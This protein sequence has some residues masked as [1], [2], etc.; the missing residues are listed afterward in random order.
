MSEPLKLSARI[1]TPM[2]E[3]HHAL[4]DAEALRVWLAEH[5]EV[6][7]P[8]RYAFWGRHTPGGEDPHQRP[9]HVDDH[10]V[11]FS[12]RLGGEDTTVEFSLEEEGAESTIVTL[13]Q[14]HFSHE[15]MMSGD[16]DLG[17]LHTFWAMAIANLADHLEGRELLPRCDFTSSRME[18]RFVI[19]ASPEAVYDSLIDSEK[20]TRWFGFPVGIEPHVGGRFAMG[21]LD[22]GDAARIID[23]DPGRKLVTDWGPTGVTTWELEGTGGKTRLTFVQS[24][25]DTSRP[26]YGAW[27]G[28][29]SGLAELR[30]FHEVPGWQPM[31]V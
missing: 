4:T 26:P 19:D 9:L 21:G 12:W 1:A 24:G 10:T 30:R 7:L 11:R 6:D 27:M 3:V 16:S 13:T 22:A 2:K 17:L 18:G 14:T 28:W 29:L 31:W 8:D 20:V 25:F 23:L 5:A 15:A